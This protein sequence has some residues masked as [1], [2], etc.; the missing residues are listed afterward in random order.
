MILLKIFYILILI[1]FPFGQLTK[2]PL[3][4]SEINIYFQD[5][6]L[7]I[8]VI[9]WII[10]H[11]ITRRP[12]LK[13]PITKPIILFII[14]AIFSLITNFLRFSQKEMIIASLYLVR[15]GIFT[16]IYFITFEMVNFHFIDQSKIKWMLIYVGTTTAIFGLGQYILYPNLRNLFYLGWDPHYF[17]VFGT[18]FDPGFI[19]VIIILTIILLMD[20][21]TKITIHEQF[22]RN[23]CFLLLTICYVVL[24]LTYSRSCY[25]AFITGMG[26]ISWFKRN[27]KIILTAMLI[28]ITTIIV[29]PRPAGSEGVKLERGETIWGRLQNWKQSIIIF[30]NNPLLGVGFNTYRYV[31]KNYGYI[32]QEDWQTSHSGAGADSS[33]LFILATTGICGLISYLLLI[34]YILIYH[35]RNVTVISS[36]V[37]VLVSSWFANSLF[38]PWIMLWMWILI[39]IQ[40][41][42][43]VS[44]SIRK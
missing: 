23:A 17:R 15:W 30:K 33:L 34:Y 10:W 29:L 20:C 21:I 18:F 4:I 5:I 14:V 16:S 40:V 6:I 19:G 39:G 13:T 36:I 26:V 2:L 42:S 11:L 38:Y 27:P 22:Y 12:L 35:I 7:G 44:R 25:L 31:Q 28:I 32:N 41:K 43:T 24:A 3:G 9:S 1:I 8:L 37:V